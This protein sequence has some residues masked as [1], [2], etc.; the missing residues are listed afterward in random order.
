M[1]RV[2]LAERHIYHLSTCRET[3]GFH[4]DKRFLGLGIADRD[5]GAC[6]PVC[7]V[8]GIFALDDLPEKWK[9]FTEMNAKHY[10]C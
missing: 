1:E 10:G 3:F 2:Y 5:R 4:M 8:S 7:P 9:H 6:V